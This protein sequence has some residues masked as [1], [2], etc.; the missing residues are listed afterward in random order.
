MGRVG[1]VVKSQERTRI[2][3]QK[4]DYLYAEFESMVFGFVDDVEFYFD[5]KTGTLHVRSASRIGKSDLGVNRE[6]VN[7]IYSLLKKRIRSQ[8]PSL[9]LIC[10][11][12]N[13]CP[14][15]AA[16]LLTQIQRSPRR[17]NSLRKSTRHK[18]NFWVDNETRRYADPWA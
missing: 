4:D 16:C 12:L 10:H 8:K 18:E 14:L 13:P 15:G 2:I 17:I 9:W 1:R 7:L 6:R 11:N 3:T 5:S